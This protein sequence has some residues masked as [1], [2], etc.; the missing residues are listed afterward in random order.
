VVIINLN[1][2]GIFLDIEDIYTI[3]YITTL[4]NYTPFEL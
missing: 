4:N 1:G 3:Y 2:S